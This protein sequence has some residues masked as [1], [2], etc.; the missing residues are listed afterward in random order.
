MT[1]IPLIALLFLLWTNIA[2]SQTESIQKL[3]EQTNKL[4]LNINELKEFAESHIS[5]DY[6]LAQFF[7]YW[8]G[9]NITYDAY[10]FEK[11][12][13]GISDEEY[14]RT[15]DVFQVFK[16]KMA[17]CGGYTQLY[18]WF[19]NEVGIESVKVRG[20]IRHVK[21]PY[22]QYQS[23]HKYNH[24]WNAV[25]IDNKW[26]LVDPT[27]STINKTGSKEFY[28]DMHPEMAINSHFPRE[29]KWQLLEEPMTISE[30]KNSNYVNPTW[31]YVGYTDVPKI[32]S[33]NNYYYFSFRSHPNSKMSVN[34]SH[35]SDNETFK[36]L[37]GITPIKQDGITS[38]RINKSAISKHTYLKVNVSELKLENNN[39][40]RKTYQNV[41]N[42]R[43]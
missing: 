17:I 8:I 35:S 16:R 7:Y 42:I 32:T 11:F 21:N 31:F 3:V 10:I 1:R 19:L 2:F 37:A 33:D 9:D 30:F 22:A 24:A 15:Q 40:L 23:Q 43:I 4:N 38:Y 34:L 41:I 39:F 27:W 18:N 14:S 20:Y 26:I 6:E 28:F 36:Q 13:D 25:K 12:L 5:D 29:E